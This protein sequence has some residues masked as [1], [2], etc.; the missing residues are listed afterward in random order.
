[1]RHQRAGD[2]K[3]KGVAGAQRLSI[4]S[5][6][7]LTLSLTNHSLP[8]ASLALQ[9]KDKT[10]FSCKEEKRGNIKTQTPEDYLVPLPKISWTVSV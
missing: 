1:M 5:I 3:G 9:P 6:Q 7:T 4:N 8:E 2:G 10:Y